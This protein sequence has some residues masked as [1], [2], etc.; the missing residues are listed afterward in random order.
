MTPELERQPLTQ[1]THAPLA[2]NERSL[3]VSRNR[4][5]TMA[6]EGDTAT[7]VAPSQPSTHDD[8]MPGHVPAWMNCMPDSRSSQMPFT[9]TVCGGSAAEGGIV[10]STDPSL[11]RPYM[12]SNGATEAKYG[13]AWFMDCSTP[14]S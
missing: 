3:G 14:L 13:W 1:F 7:G 8:G 11:P 6:D 2:G 5:G 9:A 4:A 10:S 12:R